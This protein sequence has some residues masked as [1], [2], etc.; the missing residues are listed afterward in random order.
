MRK[1]V[2]VK[3]TALFYF[4]ENMLRYQEKEVSVNRKSALCLKMLIESAG[5][6]TSQ[7]EI[8][9]RCWSDGNTVVTPLS[10]RQTLFQLRQ[11]ISEL[12]LDSAILTTVRG[13]GYVLLPGFIILATADNCQSSK[14]LRERE[15]VSETKSEAEAVPAVVSPV[16][17][18]DNAI[19]TGRAFLKSPLIALALAASLCLSAGILFYHDSAGMVKPVTYSF[20]LRLG[21]VQ[22]YAQDGY[23]VSSASLSKT[24]QW[25]I[26]RR[27]IHADMSNY[28][29]I[30]GAYSSQTYSAYICDFPITEHRTQC[31]SL[32]VENK[33]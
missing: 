15:T 28:I 17:T 6:V 2:T 26:D 30:N 11:K 18:P 23:S 21:K 13:K 29:Y 12:G 32:I 19:S 7:E 5:R 31:Y 16:V 8:L 9:K 33:D 25:L 24:T 4:D 10:V 1:D 27:Y 3:Q 20:V 14:L 22:V